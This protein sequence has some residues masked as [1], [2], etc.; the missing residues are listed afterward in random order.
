MIM[1]YTG[2]IWQVNLNELACPTPSSSDESTYKIILFYTGAI[3][4]NHI[5]VSIDFNRMQRHKLARTHIHAHTHM[6]THTH[7]F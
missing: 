1:F 5:R 4:N 2:A 3:K 7:Y 6:H